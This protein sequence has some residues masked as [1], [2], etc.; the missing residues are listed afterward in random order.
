MKAWHFMTR[1][2]LQM[3]LHLHVYAVS[4]MVKKVVIV[5]VLLVRAYV[6]VLEL[7]NHSNFSSWQ[8]Y[9]SVAEFIYCSLADVKHTRTILSF[10]VESN[11][12]NLY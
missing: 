1:L 9:L 3:C 8:Y 5:S 2:V 11:Q 12:I 7:E 4:I 10:L 6:C